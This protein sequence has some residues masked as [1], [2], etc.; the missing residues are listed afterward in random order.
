MREFST[1]IEGD[2]H[3]CKVVPSSIASPVATLGIT[4]D[5]ELCRMPCMAG[6][7]GCMSTGCGDGSRFCSVKICACTS[8]FCAEGES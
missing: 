2:M 4:S 5:E 8:S 1:H 3:S 7:I 6:G